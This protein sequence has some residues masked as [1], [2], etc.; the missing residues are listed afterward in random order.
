[1]SVRKRFARQA[2]LGDSHLMAHHGTPDHFYR[3]MEERQVEAVR[4]RHRIDLSGLKS[5]LKMTQ[6][7]TENVI[8]KIK[9]KSD[10]PSIYILC[11]GTNN[12]RRQTSMD[13]VE[14]IVGWHEV[15]AKAVRETERSV[16]LVI[17]PIPDAKKNTQP[18]MEMLHYKLEIAM[19]DADY[20]EGKIYD[21]IYYVNFLDKYLP[22][23]YDKKLYKDPVHLNALGTRLLAKEIFNKLIQVPNRVFGFDELLPSNK[24]RKEFWSRLRMTRTR[25]RDEV[26]VFLRTIREAA[27]GSN[28]YLQPLPFGS[29]TVIEEVEEV[30]GE[31][32]DLRQ[33]LK[34]RRATK[35]SDTIFHAVDWEME[36]LTAVDANGNPI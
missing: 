20:V 8:K 34:D 17:S 35:D 18:F 26:D 32:V 9:D 2:W 10:R 15:I 36:D 4:W 30:H 24:Q 33:V 13:E 27:P 19:A 3:L 14:K 23:R 5:G 16:L 25:F 28:P 29:R 31:Q 1:M 11:V 21:C 22:Y 12:V 7:W 6:E